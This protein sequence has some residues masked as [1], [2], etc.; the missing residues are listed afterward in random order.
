MRKNK[1]ANE[2]KQV[3]TIRRI[4]HMFDVSPRLLKHLATWQ[5]AY[6]VGKNLNKIFYKTFFSTCLDPRRLSKQKDV[7][8]TS[9]GLN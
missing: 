2:T 7:Y 6:M 4:C 5:N 3:K 9:Y 1:V 8:G